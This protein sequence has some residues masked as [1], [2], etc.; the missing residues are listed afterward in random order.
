MAAQLGNTAIIV[1]R[2]TGD[3]LELYNLGYMQ[4]PQSLMFNTFLNTKA[5]RRCF[6]FFDRMRL[7]FAPKKV[8]TNFYSEWTGD[9][10][11]LDINMRRYTILRYKSTTSPEADDK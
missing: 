8:T 11:S 2:E 5:K 1:Y 7:Y 9:G 6:L 10:R 3:L 4:P